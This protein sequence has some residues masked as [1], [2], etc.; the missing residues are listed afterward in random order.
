MEKVD[1][2]V[3]VKEWAEGWKEGDSPTK[4]SV[5][6][7][8]Y[9]V[10]ILITLEAQGFTCE[11]A[12]ANTGRALRGKV[13]RVDLVKLPDGWHYRKYPYGWTARTKPMTDEVKTD[14]EI[15]QIISWC[16]GHQW[17]TREWPGGFRAFMGE[18][19]PV[20]DTKAIMSMRRKVEADMSQGRASADNRSQ[21]DFAYD[22]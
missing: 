19:L 6:K 22:F 3:Q 8:G 4:E 20:R 12:D 14:D 10:G 7:G 15:A 11:M 17:A 2:Y 16:K 13:I 1:H 21:F 18:P 5:I 9:I